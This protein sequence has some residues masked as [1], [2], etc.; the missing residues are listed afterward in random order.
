MPALVVGFGMLRGMTLRA[1]VVFVFFA[2]CPP[3]LVGL[4]SLLGYRGDLWLW[5]VTLCYVALA[6]WVVREGRRPR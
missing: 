1:V 6:T 3:A 2:V 5:A 4:W